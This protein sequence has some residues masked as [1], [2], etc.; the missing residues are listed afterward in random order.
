MKHRKRMAVLGFGV[1]WRKKIRRYTFI[2]YDFISSHEFGD[3]FFVLAMSRMV[4]GKR[5]PSHWRK[6]NKE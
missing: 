4:I 2:F 3:F 6:M 5:T 1:S